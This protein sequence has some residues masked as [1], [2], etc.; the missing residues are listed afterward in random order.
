M[1]EIRYGKDYDHWTGNTDARLERL[2]QGLDLNSKDWPTDLDYIYWRQGFTKK[3]VRVKNV[4]E[5]KARKDLYQGADGENLLVYRGVSNDK[6]SDQF[7]GKGSQGDLY[8]AGEGIYGN[9]SYAASRSIHST[10]ATLAKGNQNALTLAK[11]YTEPYGSKITDA[12]KEIRT[13]VFGIKKD[14]NIKTWKKGVSTKKLNPKEPHAFP[15][16]E[17]YETEFKQWQKDIKKEAEELTGLTY[18][19]TGEAAAALGIDAY[20]IPLPLLDDAKGAGNYVHYNLDYW[21]IL[22]RNAIVVSDTV[23]L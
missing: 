16:S 5:L 4:K 20:Q 3:P 11:N 17:W 22:N 23:G 19:T 15:D 9:G 14:A 7:K 13:T 2:R 18:D 12:Q 21:V 6:W 8:F 10:K 1:S